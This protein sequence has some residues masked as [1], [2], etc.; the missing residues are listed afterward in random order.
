MPGFL[1]GV[2]CMS[3]T[4]WHGE[5]LRASCESTVFGLYLRTVCV[6]RIHRTSWKECSR[7]SV[8]RILHRTIVRVA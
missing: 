8:C 2:G 3:C 4:G 1:L 6:K 7:K 5:G